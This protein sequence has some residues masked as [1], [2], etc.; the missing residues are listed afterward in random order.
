MRT[1][2]RMRCLLA[3]CARRTRCVAGR[4]NAS[5]FI[6]ICARHARARATFSPKNGAARGF[7][8]VEVLV[9]LAITAIALVAGLKAT[10]ALTDNADRQG[11]VLLAEIC[12]ENQLIALRLARSLPG[13]G[14]STSTCTQAGLSLQVLQSVQPTPNPNFRRVDAVVSEGGTQIL[15]LTTIVG[16]N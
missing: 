3:Q 9:A 15:K 8:L 13:V 5:D 10:A 7:T 4:E 6:A 2:R 16:A 1:R 12:A 11:R 14:D